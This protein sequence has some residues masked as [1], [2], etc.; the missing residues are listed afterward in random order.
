[1]KEM[2]RR[3]EITNVK[4]DLRN[5]DLRIDDMTRDSGIEMKK[6]ADEIK[7]VNEEL[8]KIRISG[9]N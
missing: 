3:D 4:D 6:K 8:R 7:T 9:K 5:V 2:V 1:M